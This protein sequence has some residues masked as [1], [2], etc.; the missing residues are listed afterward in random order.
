M[1]AGRGVFTM[2]FARYERVPAQIQQ[3]IIAKAQKDK[4]EEEE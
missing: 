3:D 4:K 2:E 1:T